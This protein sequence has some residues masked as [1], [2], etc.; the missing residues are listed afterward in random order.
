VSATLVVGGRSVG[1]GASPGGLLRMTIERGDDGAA[2]WN[3]F[4]SRGGTPEQTDFN[5]DGSQL[6]APSS[7]I[8]LN[9]TYNNINSNST[10]VAMGVVAAYSFA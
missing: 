9:N 5:H 1:C 2:R 6:S 7:A 10:I 8:A 4:V 3:E